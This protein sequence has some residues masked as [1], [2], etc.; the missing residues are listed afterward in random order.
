MERTHA[1]QSLPAC[2]RLLVEQSRRNSVNGSMCMVCTTRLYRPPL[3]PH[4]LYLPATGGSVRQAAARTVQCTRHASWRRATSWQVGGCGAGGHEVTCRCGAVN[5]QSLSLLPSPARPASPPPT[6]LPAS[7]NH[8][9]GRGGGAGGNTEGD[10]HPARVQ[11]PKRCQV[12]RELSTPSPPP[13]HPTPLGT[14]R[15]PRF[16]AWHLCSQGDA[17]ASR[18]CLRHVPA[19]SLPLP[20]PTT[21]PCIHARRGPGARATRCGFAWSTARVG[22]GGA[23]GAQRGGDASIVGAPC[24]CCRRLA[25]PGTRRSRRLVGWQDLGAGGGAGSSF[26]GSAAAWQAA[27]RPGRAPRWPHARYCA[28]RRQRV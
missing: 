8:P 28:R 5:C 9:G 2:P 24:C 11:P 12:L 19:F 22:R 25:A 14:A 18:C 26:P 6:V 16:N 15:R 4:H 13:P 21:P 23:G 17:H 7:Q 1:G 27:L 3:P 20:S 10:C